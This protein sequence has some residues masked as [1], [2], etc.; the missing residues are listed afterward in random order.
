VIFVDD[1]S[2]DRTSSIVSTFPNVKYFFQ[3]NRG[4]GSA[5]QFGISKAHGQFILVQDADLEYDV[6]DYK[7]LLAALD[8]ES[9]RSKVAIFGSRTIYSKD[10]ASKKYRYRFKPRS[11]QNLGPWLANIIL[12]AVVAV[13]YGKWISDN[14]TAYKLYSKDFFTEN[15]IVSCGFEADH[16]ITAKLLRRG[17]RIIEV[18]VSYSPRSVEDGKKIRARDGFTALKVF[19]IE[20]WKAH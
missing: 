5:V 3:E 7:V 10:G 2:T 20:R 11:G 19:L 12:S 18:P 1:G 8:E 14:L 15:E 6:N 9:V 16:E 17:Y 13:F 4:K